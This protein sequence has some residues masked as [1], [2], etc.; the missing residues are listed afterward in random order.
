MATSSILIQY[1]LPPR[2]SQS[3]SALIYSKSAKNHPFLAR[4]PCRLRCRAILQELSCTVLI[5]CRST[6]HP[7]SCPPFKLWIWPQPQPQSRRHSTSTKFVSLFES[8]THD[9]YIF[10]LFSKLL[11]FF[12]ACTGLFVVPVLPSTSCRT[13]CHML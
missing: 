4:S 7:I 11:R 1:I 2:Q 6:S 12:I 8:Q 13:H 5:F 10:D 9:R 3:S